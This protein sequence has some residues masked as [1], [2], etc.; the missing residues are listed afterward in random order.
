MDASRWTSRDFMVVCLPPV[1]HEFE[2]EKPNL[3]QPEALQ[4]TYTSL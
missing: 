2:A 1:R 3:T 4:T